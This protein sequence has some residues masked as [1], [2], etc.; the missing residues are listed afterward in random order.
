MTTCIIS[1]VFYV[2]SRVTHVQ[3]SSCPIVPYAW[4]YACLEN[5][6]NDDPELQKLLRIPSINH[7]PIAEWDVYMIATC[8]YIYGYV[9][10]ESESLH[11]F[12]L[13]YVPSSLS[14][15]SFGTFSSVVEF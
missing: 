14:I 15:G 2:S 11:L 13:V 6:L 9:D 12:S 3:P 1:Y 8:I 10:F 5:D 7:R 4:L